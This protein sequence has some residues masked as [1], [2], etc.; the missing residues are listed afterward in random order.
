MAVSGQRGPGIGLPYRV[1]NLGNISSP[2][3]FTDL[4]AGPISL[5]AGE[6]MLIPAGQ[7]YLAPGDATA[8]QVQDPVTG[9][10][11][12]FGQGPNVAGIVNSD[13][14]N[15]RLANLSGCAIGALITNVGSGYTSAPVVAASAGS[16]VWRAIVGGAVNATVTITTAGVG[17]THAPQLVVSPPP[18]GGVPATMICTVS[19]GVINAVTVINQGAGYTAAPTISIIPDSRD[20]PTTY[21]RLTATLT[22]S[23][24]ITAVVCTDN[25][26]PL[27]AVPTLS[28][29]GGGGASAAATTV[30]NFVAT[31]FTVGTA[32]VLYGNALPFGI[33]TTGGIV[34]GTPGAVVNPN[35]ANLILTPRQAVIQGTSTAGG[36]IQ[37]TGS[38]VVDAGLFQAVP[39]GL[40]I[41][42]GG[43]LPTTAGAVTITVGGSSDT[44]LLFPV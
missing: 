25:G 17:Y 11:F 41:A 31:G 7:F 38:V 3:S 6:T 26:T 12:S 27:T 30:M 16:S 43:A 33:I 18:P 1:P 8:F 10:W 42:G 24:T 20:A 2:T 14:A 13:G 36:A 4:G 37:T 5:A 21:G 44:S 28:F 19:A 39:S 9:L 40:V 22:G 34:P 32:G 23:G 29:T 15:M 35:I